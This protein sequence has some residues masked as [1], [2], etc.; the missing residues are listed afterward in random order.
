MR[1]TGDPVRAE[2]RE[3]RVRTRALPLANLGRTLQPH[4]SLLGSLTSLCYSFGLECLAALTHRPG[5]AVTSPPVS[6][7]PSPTLPAELP[8]PSW[9]PTALHSTSPRT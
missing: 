7:L 5:P 3:R 1:D 4:R 2:Q 8:A 6:G 9:A